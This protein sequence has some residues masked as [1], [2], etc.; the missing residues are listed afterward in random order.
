[1]LH[2]SVEHDCDEV[3]T[4]TPLPPTAPAKADWRQPLE[5]VTVRPVIYRPEKKRVLIEIYGIK[6]CDY[7]EHNE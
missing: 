6:P 7:A 5:N 4:P 3:E 2:R 1:M